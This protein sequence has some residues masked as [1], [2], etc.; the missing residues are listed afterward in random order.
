MTT[1]YLSYLESL[2]FAL[3]GCRVV[4]KALDDQAVARLNWTRKRFEAADQLLMDCGAISRNSKA[5][6]VAAGAADAV[7]RW[8][9]SE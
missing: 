4:I 2:Q 3:Q 7:Q 6:T 9:K 1:S 8:A 5:T